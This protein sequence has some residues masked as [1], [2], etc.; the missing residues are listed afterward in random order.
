L[1]EKLFARSAVIS[2]NLLLLSL[3]LLLLPLPLLLLLTSAAVSGR[4]I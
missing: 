3:Q 1:N 2:A 4:A